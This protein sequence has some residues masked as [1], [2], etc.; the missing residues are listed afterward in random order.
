MATGV[1]FA[2]VSDPHR[3]AGLTL[4]VSLPRGDVQSSHPEIS[5]SR[6]TLPAMNGN[7]S[8]VKR[9]VCLIRPNEREP[10]GIHENIL[11]HE[12][13]QTGFVL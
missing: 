6:E 5:D 12:L 9:K 13:K 10:A 2:G 1:Q 3:W 4:S 8:S 11:C 7:F